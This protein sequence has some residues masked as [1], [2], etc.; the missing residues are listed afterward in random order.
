M[1]IVTFM[2]SLS[3]FELSR[4]ED[5]PSSD[6]DEPSKMGE[7]TGCLHQSR[8]SRAVDHDAALLAQGSKFIAVRSSA[9]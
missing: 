9:R 8:A 5:E 1:Y 6:E 7:R 3:G 2:D 4:E